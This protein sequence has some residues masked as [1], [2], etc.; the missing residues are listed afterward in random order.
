[1]DFSGPLT[2]LD[3]M[4]CMGR[5]YIFLIYFIHIFVNTEPRMN[6]I[7]HMAMKN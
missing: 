1:M 2:V 5:K 6:R 3:N 4:T 7:G